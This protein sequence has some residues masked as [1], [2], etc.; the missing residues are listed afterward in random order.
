MTL[1]AIRRH[2]DDQGFTLIEIIIAMLIFA[3]A[4][5]AL[6]PM[7]LGMTK[8]ATFAKTY[9]QARNLAQDQVESMRQLPFHIDA[10]NQKDSSGGDASTSR[11]DLVDTYYPALTPVASGTTAANVSTGFVAASATAGRVTGDPAG[12]FF[13]TVSTRTLPGEGSSYRI[14]VT[15]QFIDGSGAAVAPQV[16]YLY[17]D[18]TGLDE[19]PSTAMAVTVQVVWTRYGK[20]KLHKTYT[21]IDQAQPVRPLVNAQARAE[22][23]RVTSTL[24]GDV[25]VTADVANVSADGSAAAGITA[26]VDA[27]GAAVSTTPGVTVAGARSSGSAPPTQT[28]ANASDNAGGDLLGIGCLTVCFGKTVVTGGSLSVDK[29]LPLV[30]Y[31]SDGT[32]SPML[33]SVQGQGSSGRP[34]FRFANVP[35]RTDLLLSLTS[36]LVTLRPKEQLG[37]PLI[38]GSA[39]GTGFAGLSTSQ[40]SGSAHNVSAKAGSCGSSGPC[41]TTATAG[42]VIDIMPTTFIP[43]GRG[44]VQIQLFG[45]AIACSTDGTTPAAAATYKADVYVWKSTGYQLVGT[46]TNGGLQL[47]DP[48]TIKVTTNL[49]VDVMLSQYIQSWSAMTT[50]D[51]LTGAAGNVARGTTD[52]IITLNTAPT[53]MSD[54]SSTVAVQ[55]SPMSCYAEDNR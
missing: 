21:R 1:N 18:K 4:I 28:V 46:A 11:V 5:S 8:A 42:S 17:S 2:H 27:L 54:P 55:V 7:F 26:S 51:V 10:S 24:P 40:I 3:V 41:P 29:A 13:R 32:G 31:A 16:G 52:G 36:P 22:L 47:P 33:A 30:G 39:D 49:G 45:A 50:L 38:G 9:T 35:D 19:V 14:L 23:L 37:L 43:S 15:G 34:A 6:I 20:T 12:A 48:S 44:V 25:Q 53:R